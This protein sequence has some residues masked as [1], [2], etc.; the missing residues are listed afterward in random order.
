LRD[1]LAQCLAHRG[2]ALVDVVI[3]RAFESML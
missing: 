3:D 2:P 1:T